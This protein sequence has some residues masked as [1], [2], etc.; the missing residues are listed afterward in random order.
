MATAALPVVSVSE[1]VCVL[2]GRNASLAVG[3]AL[4]D[5]GEV[6][7]DGAWRPMGLS[8]W[9]RDVRT[10]P[11]AASAIPAQHL[12]HLLSRLLPTP[13]C[14]SFRVVFHPPP[15]MSSQQCLRRLPGA[16]R[17]SALRAGARSAVRAP[18]ARSYS[19]ISRATSSGLLSQ[20]SRYAVPLD[21]LR[22]QLSRSQTPWT[23]RNTTPVDPGSDTNIRY[24][25]QKQTAA[26]MLTSRQPMSPPSRSPRWPSPSPRVH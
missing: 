20:V 13:I 24:M 14:L 15:A 8:G 23:A 1:G 3:C 7:A 18:A 10:G 2:C 9:T 6:Q 12:P 25:R 5:G 21:A 17:A 26:Q 4:F 16:M 19:A 22:T 11:V